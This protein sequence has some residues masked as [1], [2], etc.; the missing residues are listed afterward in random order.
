MKG[1][2]VGMTPQITCPLCPAQRGQPRKLVNFGAILRHCPPEQ[3]ER[4][5]KSGASCLAFFCGGCHRQCSLQVERSDGVLRK[6]RKQH[7][8]NLKAEKETS[9]QGD[10]L[11]I[12]EQL[13]KGELD[14]SAAA[15]PHDPRPAGHDEE[16]HHRRAHRGILPQELRSEIVHGRLVHARARG[17]EH[18]EDEG[19][20]RQHY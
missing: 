3:V 13:K 2:P 5:R 12:I 7:E 18:H 10:V 16:E 9:W 20:E 11:T 15:Q 17:D 4:C 8:S 6:L 1:V 14:A 19:A